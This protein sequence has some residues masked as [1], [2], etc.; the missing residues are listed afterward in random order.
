MELSDKAS[1]L[2][3]QTLPRLNWQRA[4][5]LVLLGKETEGF[6]T[7]IGLLR[8]YTNHIDFDKFAGE[9]RSLLTNGTAKAIE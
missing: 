7:M 8:Q 3:Q 5:D 9:L 4:S 2:T 6:S 1:Q